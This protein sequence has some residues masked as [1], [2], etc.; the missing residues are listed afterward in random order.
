MAAPLRPSAAK[1]TLPREVLELCNKVGQLPGLHRDQLAVLCER[2][3]NLVLLQSRLLRMAQD[4]V[5]NLELDVKYLL[6]DLEVTRRERDAYQQ[7]LE[8][9]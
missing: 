9:R 1:E 2:V 8:N 5:E 3:G 7:E 4:M 6:F